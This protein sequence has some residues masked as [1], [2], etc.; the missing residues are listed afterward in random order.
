LLG[1]LP[2]IC[3]DDQFGFQTNKIDD[4]GL[5]NDLTPELETFQAASSKMPPQQ[6]FGIGGLLAQVTCP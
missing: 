2:A 5:N 1:V 3:F 6:L 4:V